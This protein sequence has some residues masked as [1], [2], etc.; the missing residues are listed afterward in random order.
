[1]SPVDFPNVGSRV[2]NK[3]FEAVVLDESGVERSLG[4]LW[5]G[6]PTLVMFLRH[7]GCIGCSENVSDLAPRLPDLREL[8]VQVV[9]V[10]NGAPMFIEGF[11]ERFALNHSNVTVVTDPSLQV[12]QHALLRN[13][14]WGVMGFAG[15]RD[16]LRAFTK[17]HFQKSV[18]G[19]NHQQ[20]GSLFL[21]ET[22]VVKFYHR[23]YSLGGHA[24][25]PSGCSLFFNGRSGKDKPSPAM[26]RLKLEPVNPCGQ[27]SHSGVVCVEG[28]PLAA[29]DQ[30]DGICLL[31]HLLL[32]PT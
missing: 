19:N 17:G 31:Y 12:H 15:I 26:G 7:F 2:P 28:H 22:G 3:L 11:K 14:F 9:L 30:C 8:G 24:R 32:H 25:P 10:G 23:N 6:Q 1:M 20:G 21:D 16:M 13:S 4:S 18:Q 27:Q 5:T 29:I